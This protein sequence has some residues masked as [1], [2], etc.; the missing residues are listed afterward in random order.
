M[1]DALEPLIDQ[2]KREFREVITEL[3]V[4]SNRL[5]HPVPVKVA[6]SVELTVK[7]QV[8]E[9]LPF[10][11]KVVGNAP[12]YE[13]PVR[14][15]EVL[16]TAIETTATSSEEIQTH[17]IANGQKLDLL[18]TQLKTVNDHLNQVQ[19]DTGTLV[20]DVQEGNETS[21][22]ANAELV[23]INGHLNQLELNSG[24]S[25]TEL[26]DANSTLDVLERDLKS[27]ETSVRD[28]KDELVA[29]NAELLVID[30]L[31][32]TA[33]GE[34]VIIDGLLTT[35]SAEL[36]VIDGQMVAQLASDLLV[37]TAL[38]NIKDSVA[39]LRQPLPVTFDSGGGVVDVNIVGSTG[40]VGVLVNNDIVHPIPTD[41][42][43]SA[44]IAVKPASGAVFNTNVNNTAP[45][46]V[47]FP[48]S[49]V[50]PVNVTNA[51]RL[52]QNTAVVI[53]KVNTAVGVY[54]TAQFNVHVD[55]FPVEQ[56]VKGV[57]GPLEVRTQMA[58]F[59]Q[60][61]AT[62]LPGHDHGIMEFPVGIVTG[63]SHSIKYTGNLVD[64]TLAQCGTHEGGVSALAVNHY[65]H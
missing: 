24:L 25:L 12:D 3:G 30:G 56:V 46:A 38:D 14:L 32:V 64:L 60:D 23:K 36:V 2:L 40:D 13:L 6:E 4:I 11:V 16:S 48:P 7:P 63:P 37:T 33:N 34:L 5:K 53:D 8:E 61:Q 58:S 1:S 57:N 9:I 43:Q 59:R 15:N 49:Y 28:C 20:I 27:V 41:V 35:C 62:L 26:Q 21:V 10:H 42:R 50:I 54:P 22:A 47:D 19:L 17:T 29:V 31:L 65:N 52:E 55:N 39:H 51:V 18:E 44:I 45:I